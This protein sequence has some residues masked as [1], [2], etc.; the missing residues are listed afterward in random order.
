MN[1]PSNARPQSLDA[2]GIAV[3]TLCE[4]RPFYWSVRRELWENRSIYVA[5]LAAG[6]FF[7]LGFLAS[8]VR[9]PA[10]MRAAAMDETKLHAVAVQ[11]YHMAAGLLMVTAMIVGLVYCL[12]ALHGERRDRSILFWKS[13]PV[14]DWTTVL[15]KASIP[16][17][18][19]PL[20][21]FLITVVLQVL[22]VAVGIAALTGSD[23]GVAALWGHLP[24]LRMWCLLLYHLVTVHAI[25]HA[26][27]Y[28]WLLLISAWARRAPFL[29]AALP[30][31]AIAIV[32]KLLFNTSYF[33]A[34]LFHWLEGGMEA[35]TE[36]GSM[37]ID[38]MTHLTPWRYLGAPGLWVGL[39]CTALFL[40]GAVRLR[41]YRDPN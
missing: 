23:G 15:S 31:V 27:L 39:A 10:K 16:L 13:L 5:P 6:G 19:L 26:P 34:K 33:G 24:L 37:P 36:D 12:D 20:G 4:T 30:P 7:F 38:A 18:I 22:M 14:S 29:W 8:L 41:R 17:V 28:A 1:A 35:I 40:A 32:E 3:A 9:F 21:A 25:W 2:A 11:P